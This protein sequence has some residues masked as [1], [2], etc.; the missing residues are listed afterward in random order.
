VAREDKREVAA[1]QLCHA[2]VATAPKR[3]EALDR[4]VL[5]NEL[6][7]QSLVDH[8]QDAVPWERMERKARQEDIPLAAKHWQ[9]AVVPPAE[10]P[11]RH[12]RQ[13]SPRGTPHR[14]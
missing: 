7:V 14:V 1:C 3:D 10:P 2:H 5:G 4:G 13:L 6:L 8:Y 9:R 12:R 11:F